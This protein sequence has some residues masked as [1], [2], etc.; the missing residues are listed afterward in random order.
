MKTDILLKRE[1]GIDSNPKGME[2][3]WVKFTD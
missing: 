1:K 2:T 3:I